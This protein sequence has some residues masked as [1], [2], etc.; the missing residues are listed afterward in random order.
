MGMT[1]DRVADALAGQALDHVRLAR[2]DDD[3]LGAELLGAQ[4]VP[5]TEV[6]EDN[7]LQAAF[8]R[9]AVDA[10]LLF[11]HD[12]PAQMNTFAQIGA[13]PLFTLG[14]IDE[15]GRPV[16]DPC[17]PDV[18]TFVEFHEMIR[19]IRPSG[20]LFDAWTAAAAASQLEFGLVLPQ[21]TPASMVA[22]WR[23]AGAGAASATDVQALAWSLDLRP[24]GGTAATAVMGA[25]CAS[26]PAL[27]ALRGWLSGR[28]NWRP[29]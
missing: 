11:G 17:F 23:R 29:A 22:L 5:V 28:S 27:L 16:R 3:H 18:P 2:S 24:L 10:L 14:V 9:G 12:V 15:A 8:A 21:L 13:R 1:G 6:Q 26:Q 7:A 4:P 20:P 25:L 19:G